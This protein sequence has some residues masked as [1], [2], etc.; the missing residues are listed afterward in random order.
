MLAL[1][2]IL[3]PAAQLEYVR[4]QESDLSTLLLIL[5]VTFDVQGFV[6]EDGLRNER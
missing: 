1:R 3:R 2:A 6:S 4:S 5:Y